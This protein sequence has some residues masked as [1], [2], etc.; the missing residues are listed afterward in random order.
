MSYLKKNNDDKNPEWVEKQTKIQG[1]DSPR[2]FGEWR[3]LQNVTV[4][5][6]F[7][8]CHGQAR[9]VFVGDKRDLPPFNDGILIMG[10]YK[11]LWNW[12]DEFIPYYMATMGV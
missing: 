5:N 3:R 2:A 9:R 10:P 8:M 1:L 4:W 7:H 11:P 6:K 12:V